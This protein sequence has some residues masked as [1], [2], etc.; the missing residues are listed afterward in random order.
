MRSSRKGGGKGSIDIS[1]EILHAVEILK[2]L[3]GIEGC[4]ELRMVTDS[5]GDS[6]GGTVSIGTTWARGGNLSDWLRGSHQGYLELE[7]VERVV[8]EAALILASI[9]GKGVFHGDV[10]LENIL[11]KEAKSGSQIML[12][13]FCTAFKFSSYIDGD[14]FPV[15]CSPMYVPPEVLHPQPHKK[16]YCY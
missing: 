11:F 15:Q 16:S 13:D 12:V 6:E 14:P 1:T 2:E 10:K 4:E 3:R 9:H 8:A 7:E 5:R